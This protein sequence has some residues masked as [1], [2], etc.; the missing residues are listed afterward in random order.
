MN[1][2]IVSVVLRSY[3]TPWINEL[4]ELYPTPEE[5]IEAII[6]RASD[7]GN[8]EIIELCEWV[9]EKKLTTVFFPE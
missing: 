4:E 1:V 9:I 3:V 6:N 7:E 8:D 2:A 5:K